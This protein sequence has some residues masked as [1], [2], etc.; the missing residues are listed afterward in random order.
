MLTSPDST[1]STI[2]FKWSNLREHDNFWY[3]ILS[4]GSVET[5]ARCGEIFNNHVTTNF[6][7]NLPVKEF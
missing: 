1:F 5:Y 2:I 7:E 4:P 6:L 3:Q